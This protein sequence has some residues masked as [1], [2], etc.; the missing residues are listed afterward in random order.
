MTDESCDLFLLGTQECDCIALKEPSQQNDQYHHNKHGNLTRDSRAWKKPSIGLHLTTGSPP[1]PCWPSLLGYWQT[2]EHVLTQSQPHLEG[3]PVHKRAV[4]QRS[5][6][7]VP[8]KLE[9]E[10]TC[11]VDYS[12]KFISYSPI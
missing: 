12:N 4:R 9:L 11:K 3:D 1:C 8:C 5:A 10:V 6:P 2:A 7:A